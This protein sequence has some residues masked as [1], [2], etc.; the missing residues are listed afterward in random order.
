MARITNKVL[1]TKVENI[2]N[3]LGLSGKSSLFL[4]FAY[5]G[6]R[7]C[8]S[9]EMGGCSDVSPR[10]TRTAMSDNL[11]TM[12]NAIYKLNLHIN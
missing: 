4:E 2:N 3:I 9:L 11:D 1:E 5:G 7:L 8:K 10:M 6:V 12:I